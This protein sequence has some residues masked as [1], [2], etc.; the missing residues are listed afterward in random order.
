MKPM[1]ENKTQKTNR[2]V[3]EFL[4]GIADETRRN[5]C[6]SLVSMMTGLTGSE[7]RLW[8]DSIVGFGDVHYKYDSGREGD[9][10]RVGFSSR[11]QNITIYMLHGFEQD[12]MLMKKLGKYK[13]GK[14]CLYVNKLSDIDLPTLKT[15]ITKSLSK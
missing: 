11:R 10:F 6:L 2:S 12:E 14:S 9:W 4:R 3:D 5:D 13:T 7:P 1:P 15:L 8:G